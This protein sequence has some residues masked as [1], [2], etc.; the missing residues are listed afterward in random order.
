MTREIRV[1]GVAINDDNDCYVIAEIG[2]NHQGN[3]ETAKKLF[4]SAKEC[5]CNAVKLQKRDNK[6]LFTKELYNQVYDN[7]NSFGG[8]YGQHREALEFGRDE[9]MEL[10]RYAKELGITMFATAFDIPSADFLD[11]LDMPAY[12]IASSDLTNTPL[13]KHVASFQKPV[14]ISTGGG[15]MDDVRRAYE[16]ITA[17]NP[18]LC[19]MQCTSG[20]PVD[21]EEMNLKVIETFRSEFKDAVI[22]LSAHDNGIAMPLVGYVLGARV[23]EKH[24]TLNRTMKGTDHVFSLNHEGMRRMVRDLRRARV[25][26]GDGVK[27]TY[28]S[29]KAPLRKMGKMLCADRDL[30]A[31]HVLTVADIGIRSPANG[32]PPCEIDRLVGRKLRVAVTEDQPLSFDDLLDA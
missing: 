3:I 20:Y 12:K 24:F 29:E 30:P 6:S 5:G 4:A 32:L 7:P 16:T 26:L 25:A 22:G 10:Q 15:T 14:F 8:T 18:H 1:D 21:F 23:V 27:H 13:L 28:D 9:Y 31:G 17:I 19:I 11:S 2:H